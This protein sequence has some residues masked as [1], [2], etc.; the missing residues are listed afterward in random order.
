[1]KTI[2][3]PKVAKKDVA[4]EKEP[5]QIDTNS[6]ASK[7]MTWGQPVDIEAPIKKVAVHIETEEEKKAKNTPLDWGRLAG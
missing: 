5:I 2:K 6:S 3:E 4:K 1:M 7:A